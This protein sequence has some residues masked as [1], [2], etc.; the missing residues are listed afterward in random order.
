MMTDWLKESSITLFV[1]EFESIQAV[2]RPIGSILTIGNVSVLRCEG[3]RMLLFVVIGRQML[4]HVLIEVRPLRSFEGPAEKSR[5]YISLS[6]SLFGHRIKRFSVLLRPKAI[7][8]LFFS[9]A[10][11]DA[12]AS[13]F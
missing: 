10:S 3:V 5:L 11:S 7:R 2:I 1:A 12:P 4:E 8:I 9:P 13:L 6:Y